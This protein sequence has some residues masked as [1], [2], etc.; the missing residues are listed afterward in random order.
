VE[1]YLVEKENMRLVEL[2][3]NN[4]TFTEH[5]KELQALRDRIKQLQDELEASWQRETLLNEQ[6]D[7]LKRITILIVKILRS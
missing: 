7:G 1:K 2:S 3:L 5:E 6:A 4:K